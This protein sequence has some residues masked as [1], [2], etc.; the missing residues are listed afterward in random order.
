MQM[1]GIIRLFGL[2]AGLMLMF[3]APA[4]ALKVA[5]CDG[6]ATYRVVV[7]ADG[8]LREVEL[9]PMSAAHLP[10]GAGVKIGMADGGPRQWARPGD[11]YCVFNG[12]LTI[13]MRSTGERHKMR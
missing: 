9:A 11:Y 3:A 10:D 13:Q 4:Q 1:R 6:K 8:A 2:T 7:D 5:N 12:K